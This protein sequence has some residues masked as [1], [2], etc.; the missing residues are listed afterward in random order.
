[1]RDGE[2]ASNVGAAALALKALG[3]VR[4]LDELGWRAEVA[5]V[6]HPDPA[7]AEVYD[8]LYEKFTEAYRLLAPFFRE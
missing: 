6:V 1:M 2:H 7:L 5:D 8:V 3:A 4:D